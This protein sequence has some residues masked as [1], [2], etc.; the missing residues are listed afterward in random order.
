VSIVQPATIKVEISE[1]TFTIPVDRGRFVGGGFE[2]D[3]EKCRF[4]DFEVY[5]PTLAQVPLGQLNGI[6][7]E[8]AL[9]AAI[10]AW[11]IK[12]QDIDVDFWMGGEVMGTW[13]H[14]AARSGLWRIVRPIGMPGTTVWQQYD[15]WP[16]VDAEI[17][18]LGKLRANPKFAVQMYR[19]SSPE[20]DE[21]TGDLP[22][23]FSEFRFGGKWAVRFPKWASA[24]LWKMAGGQ[25]KV[26]ARK[27]WSGGELYGDG[28]ANKD[29]FVNVLCL[30]GKLLIKSNLAEDSWLYSET[31]A[32]NVPAAPVAF[33]STGGT[34]YFGLH[35]ITFAQG[36]WNILVARGATTLDRVPTMAA[37]KITLGSKPAGTLA[38]VYA[39]GVKEIAEVTEMQRTFRLA[40]KLWSE[41]GTDTPV[42]KM[43]GLNFPPVT[44]VRVP[45]WRDVTSDFLGAEGGWDCSL[46]ER[47]VT[48]RYTVRL[49]NTEGQYSRMRGNVRLRIWAS[50][51]APK[52][53]C[54]SVA[55]V[56]GRESSSFSETGISFTTI[57]RLQALDEIEIGD[58]PAL[59]GMNISDAMWHILSWGHVWDDEIGEIYDS[60]HRLPIGAGGGTDLSSASTI[61]ADVLETSGI[62]ACKLRPDVTVRRALR[63]LLNFDYNTFIAFGEDGKFYYLAPGQGIYRTYR[64]TL[65]PEAEDEIREALSFRPGLREGKT[66][67]T[68]GGS[69][70]STGRPLSS[71]AYDYPAL[72]DIQS[73]RYRGYDATKRVDDQNLNEQ[74]LLDMRCRYEFEWM[75]RLRDEVS[76]AAI[77]QNL[78]P[79]IRIA[80]MSDRTGAT[81]DYYILNVNEE[82]APDGKWDMKLDAVTAA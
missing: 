76:F 47:A 67:V 21:E 46:E 49:Q 60:G 70:R 68:V 4:R 29:M 19:E 42:V 35:E 16:D 69:E 17:T 66:S 13:A 77:G 62:A 51:G 57:D 22:Y 30:D 36:E 73:G 11:G 18:S 64:E 63:W 80:V 6:V 72:A 25:W 59:D 28:Y 44:A 1:G 24:E 79:A 10:L 12:P 27:D 37:T 53:R 48:Q 41:D 7:Y 71:R 65:S 3:G 38:K 58:R 54:T 9:K 14:R 32:I 2:W 20:A 82:I 39:A 75:R 23:I 43:A 15:G 55:Q 50:R 52:V 8:E 61:V 31:T 34:G 45:A 81:K 5:E 74:R 40:V 26:V 33:R 56:D 78:V